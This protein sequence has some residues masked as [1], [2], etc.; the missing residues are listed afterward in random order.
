MC[1]LFWYWFLFILYVVK[2]CWFSQENRK[3]KDFQ[4]LEHLL[5]IGRILFIYL[6]WFYF[7]KWYISKD[8]HIVIIRL[9]ICKTYFDICYVSHK[10]IGIIIYFHLYLGMVSPIE[11]KIL[12]ILTSP[13]KELPLLFW[14]YLYTYAGI[15]LLSFVFSWDSRLPGFAFNNQFI[16]ISTRL[17]SEYVYGFGEMEH[18][19]FKRDLNWHTWGMFTRDQPPGVSTSIWLP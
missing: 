14:S 9:W 16:Q 2:V 4:F 19:T 5:L 6:Y 13:K 1:Y 17:P 7:K 18:T 12:L 10:S 11:G 8:T 15:Q 3:M